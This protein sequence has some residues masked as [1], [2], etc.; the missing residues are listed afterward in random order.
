MKSALNFLSEWAQ[1]EA[2][3]IHVLK[4]VWTKSAI[5]TSRL[6]GEVMYLLNN[7]QQLETAV[8]IETE[9]TDETVLVIN[10]I[11]N[12]RNINALSNDVHFSLGKNLNVFYGEN[13]SGKSSYVRIFRKLADNYFTNEKHL[14][15]IPN[16]Y[17]ES[18]ITD[19]YS[20][21]VEVRC[22]VN[23]TETYETIYI[24]EPHP[25]LSKLN[26]FDS[27]SVLPLINSDLSFS[28]LPKGFEMFQ[29]VSDQLDALRREASQIIEREKI[30]QSALFEDS[31]FDS[32][33]NDLDKIM[34]EVSQSRNLKTYLDTHYP[35][36]E[37]YDEVISRL[38]KEIRE[39]ESSNP[40]DKVKILSA[41]KT[42]LESI[43]HSIEQ[44]AVTLSGENIGKINELIDEYE[45][46]IDEERSFNEAF[47]RSI[48]FL[49][50]INDEWFAFIQAGKKYYDSVHIS[51]VM[52]G[53]P[54]M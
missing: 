10:E 52:E 4:E 43:K 12:P 38:E 24:N 33:R 17:A 2:W 20:Q 30:K 31:S 3:K 6:L 26:V 9:Q 18:T 48:A 29:K 42:K 32:L 50:V 23:G 25:L 13:G 36:S 37:R 44:M 15:I 51:Q 7:Q 46:K 1:G 21:T 14:A 39:L 8:T 22:S 28:V 19:D 53:A 16:V 49:E 27:D 40:R 5:D 35:R 41:Q 47:R 34:K 54:C 45:R 11:R